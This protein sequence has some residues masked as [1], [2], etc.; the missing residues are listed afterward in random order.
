MLGRDTHWRQGDLLTSESAFAL[1]LGIQAGSKRRAIV[2]THDCDLAHEGE[3]YVEVIVA[4]R[5]A[6]LDPLLS[7]A[8]N[9]R[10]L[11]LT[12]EGTAGGSLVLH[13]RHGDRR[14]ISKA[15]FAEHAKKD[16]HF[17][18]PE[19]E[20]RVLKQWLAARYG[21]TAFPNAFEQRLRKRLGKRTVEQQI[22][23][24]LAPEAKYLV[25]LFFDLGEL[26]GREAEEG[27]P[28]ALSISVVYDAMEG[29]QNARDSAERVAEQLCDLFEKAYGRPDIAQEIALERCEAVPDTYLS[30]A[31]LRR[32]DQWRLEYISLGD[33]KRG[34]FLPVG[35]MPA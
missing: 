6:K 2:I 32:V 14:C 17:I 9:P 26:R 29:G 22:A 7:Y 5:V 1:D 12:Y 34:G 21:R 28:Y 25:G 27:Q 4:D 31:D 11:H 24:I 20:K 18:L 30:L 15:D 19:N 23:K 10:Q 33:D 16:T 13:L 3:Q 35:E 8:K